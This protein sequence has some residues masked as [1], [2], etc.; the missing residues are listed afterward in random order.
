MT[1]LLGHHC[2]KPLGVDA[3]TVSAQSEPIISVSGRSPA[4]YMYTLD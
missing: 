1:C 3:L 4:S 2:D